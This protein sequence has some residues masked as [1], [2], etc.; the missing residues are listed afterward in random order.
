MVHSI[1]V[2]REENGEFN[3]FYLKLRLYHNKHLDNTLVYQSAPFTIFCVNVAHECSQYGRISFTI[4]LVL[5]N[6]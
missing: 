4:Q 3:S 1:N 5:K 2:D 6:D